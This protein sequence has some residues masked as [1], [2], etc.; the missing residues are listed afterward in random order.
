MTTDLPSMQ[1]RARRFLDSCAKWLDEQVSPVTKPEWSG[2]LTR[3]R[4][5]IARIREDLDRPTTARIALV[6]TTGAGKSSLLNA[7]LGAEVL[8]VGVM[9]PCTSFVTTVGRSKHSGYAVTVRFCTLE[10]W[11]QELQSL[12]SMIGDDDV[13]A[14]DSGRDDG[15]RLRDAACKRIRAV[16][17]K[18]VDPKTPLGSLFGELL[19]D[20]VASVFDAGPKQTQ[21]FDDSKAMQ[22]YVRTLV[23]D[24]SRLWPL[25]REVRIEG[26]YSC[27]QGDL[28][29]VDLPGLNDPNEARIEVTR[30]Y[31]RS[32]PFVWVVFNM[33]RGLTDDIQRILREEKLLRTMVLSGSYEGLALVGTKADDIDADSDVIRQLGLPENATQ[34]EIVRAYRTRTEAT[35]RQQLRQMVLDLGSRAED[36]DTLRRMLDVVDHLRVHTTSS[37][38]YRQLKKIGRSTKHYGLDRV[39][40]TGIPGLHEHLAVIASSTDAARKAEQSV[41]RTEQLVEEVRL[42]F[43]AK[44]QPATTGIAE[45]RKRIATELDK[46]S[47][48]ISTERNRATDRF[49]ERKQTFLRRLDPLLTASV[50]GVR[51][52]TDTWTGVHWGTLRALMQRDGCFRSSNGRTYDLNEDIADPLLGQLPVAWEHFFTDELGA[53]VREFEVRVTEKGE[54]FC[55]KAQMVLEL[56]VQGSSDLLDSNLKWFREKVRIL[57][58]DA[59][60]RILNQVQ[61]R[62]RELAGHIPAVAHQQ[63]RPTYNAC[64]L[65][66]G[67]GMKQRILARLVPGAVQAAR[68]IYDTV[69]HDLVTGL[70]ELQTAIVGLL[71]QVTDASVQQGQTVA[72]NTSVDAGSA[73][74]PVIQRLLHSLPVAS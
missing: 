9:E 60:S 26:P 3:W 64:K 50:Q 7:V 67:S 42:F 11:E 52:V 6:G 18:D 49:A 74:D 25:V 56:T 2:D 22:G 47:G 32:V 45:A 30:D 41:A 34:T 71:H 69:Q 27:L 57:V 40:E 28:E 54:A 58:E 48:A 29:L 68:P 38:S 8:P 19:P 62:R 73:V 33:V 37:G 20:E 17:G 63:M 72:N 35:A 53:V 61:G 14:A 46:F 21:A 1:L 24:D 10:E 13:D 44:A 43:R 15:K 16:Y 23:R 39:E 12:Q 59:R 4:T 51:K 5:E 70:D 65:E 36:S 31:L 66:H 55:E